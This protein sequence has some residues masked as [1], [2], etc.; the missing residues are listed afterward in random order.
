M[1]KAMPCS[2][3]LH[4]AGARMEGREEPAAGK[5]HGPSRCACC[6][7]IADIDFQCA[8]APIGAPKGC[9]L[10]LLALNNFKSQTIAC[11]VELCWQGTFQL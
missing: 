10:A 9:W 4:R 8:G 5:G 1:P 3:L 6:Q 2:R 11:S 7:V